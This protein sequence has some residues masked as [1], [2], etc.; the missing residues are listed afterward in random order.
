MFLAIVLDVWSRRVVEWSIDKQMSVDLVLAPLNMA[1]TQRR[2][3]GVIHDSD[4]GS[5]YT[6]FALGQRCAKLGVRLSMGSIGHAHDNA[7]A[8]SFFASL[9]RE[10]IDRRNFQTQ[11]EAQMALFTYI[12]GWYNP[13]RRHSALGRIT[14]I[15]FKRSHTEHPSRAIDRLIAVSEGTRFLSGQPSGT[16]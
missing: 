7:M 2:P 9:E 5:Q 11:V 1:I 4:Q 13:R 8:E 14:P 10:L 6:S 16:G 15:N 3:T 12:E